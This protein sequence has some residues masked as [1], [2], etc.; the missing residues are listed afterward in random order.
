LR[1]LIKNFQKCVLLLQEPAKYEFSYEVKDDQSGS[2]FGH[3]EMRDGQRAQ[4]EFNVLL[5]DGRKQ[6][7]EYEAD[8][9]G[10][11]PQIRYEGEANTGGG[12][13]YPS[14]NSGNGGNNNGYPSGGPSGGQT[15]GQ[16]GNGNG[17]P[18][19]P[20]TN[21][22]YNGGNQNDNS[23]GYPSGGPGNGQNS[24]NDRGF[25][26]NNNFGNNNGK[27]FIN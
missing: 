26:N 20:R 4:G 27:I 7:V 17:Y 5:P 10:F 12:N 16:R 1:A 23:S 18:S 21:S 15:G 6:I 3:T 19:D 8:Q 11:K 24:G 2:T 13:G 22:G 25:N 14:G 9:D